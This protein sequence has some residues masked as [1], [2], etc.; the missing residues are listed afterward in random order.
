MA[1]S[2]GRF[3]TKPFTQY[4]RNISLITGEGW[5][6]H[7]IHALIE[8]DV[9]TAKELIKK[10]KETT[11]ESI[12]FTGWI[13]KCMAQ[14]VSEHKEINSY[15][16]GRKKIVYFDDVDVPIPIERK[17]DGES[18]PTIY[19][20]RKV[21]E[22]TLK[23]ISTEIRSVQQKS[24]KG[25]KQV[26]ADHFTPLEKFAFKAPMILKK[27]LLRI[28][29]HK[30]FLKKKHMGTIGVTAIGMKGRFPGWAIPL[31]GTTT[32]LFVLGGITKKPGVANGSI[33]IRDFFHITITCDHDLIDGSPLVRFIDRFTEL[34]EEG[35][36]LTDLSGH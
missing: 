20:L 36:S 33:S 6:K 8:V 16:V 28:I 35:F 29:R 19:I 13:I 25:N 27:L 15:R 4:R 9:T 22:K 31:G 18:V 2:I 21:N 10:H 11:G 3:Q 17:I 24:L 1:D 30:G 14:A 5:R 32:V 12:S 34:C 26:I 7:S 23:E